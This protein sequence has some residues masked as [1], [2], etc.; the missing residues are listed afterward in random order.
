MDEKNIKLE[1]G[2]KA[3]K[4]RKEAKMTQQQ[5]ADLLNVYR[6]DVSAFETKGEKFGLERIC[7]LFSLFGYK[8]DIMEKKTSLTYA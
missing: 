3:R 4:L 7:Q 2:K 8:L 6:E 5:V 1:L